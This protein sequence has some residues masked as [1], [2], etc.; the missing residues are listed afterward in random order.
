MTIFLSESSVVDMVE[1]L[2]HTYHVNATIALEIC[3]LE[4]G[5]K[6]DAVG[7]NGA[8]VGL[9]QWH[10]QSW[11][12]VRRLMGEAPTDCRLDPWQNIA[13]AMY[14]MG[15]QGLYTWWSTYQAAADRRYN[16]MYHK[17]ERE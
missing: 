13:T 15:C 14:A 17:G 10:K 11:E 9:Y 6:P 16:L 4:S 12:H 8:A 1:S 7:D 2:A 3:R 5:F